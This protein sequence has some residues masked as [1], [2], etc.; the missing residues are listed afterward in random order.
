M[1]IHMR[2]LMDEQIIS[3]SPIGDIENG[4]MA[5]A[6]VHV[7][8]ISGSGEVDATRVFQSV[9]SELL[10]RRHSAPR[11]HRKSQKKMGHTGG[12]K[13]YTA[14][15]VFMS[16]D[17]LLR[18]DLKKRLKKDRRNA[19]APDKANEKKDAI[20]IAWALGIYGLIIC[21]LLYHAVKPENQETRRK[22][23]KG[24]EGGG[25]FWTTG[26]VFCSMI[27]SQA[28]GYH[29]NSLD[30][31]NIR[32]FTTIPIA[33]LL[34]NLEGT[35]AVTLGLGQGSALITDHK[36]AAYDCTRLSNVAAFQ[37]PDQC[38]H[39]VSKQEWI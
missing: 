20:K 21:V 13:K 28:R 16:P 34:M 10:T 17:N 5:T 38:D 32:K 19:E 1:I 23:E 18:R 37:L 9:V 3:L 36:L 35:N 31:Y 33:I 2:A 15:N 25:S 26:F 4:N 29:S 27:C 8:H 22:D 6:K 24:R 7:S 30:F 39:L 12:T 14:K 11:L